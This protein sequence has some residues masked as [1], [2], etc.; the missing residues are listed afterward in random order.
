[1]TTLMKLRETALQL[2][3][4][5][6]ASNSRS[7]GLYTLIH[8]EDPDLGRPSV[9]KEDK[10]EHDTHDPQILGCNEASFCAA[11]ADGVPDWL[12]T[13]RTHR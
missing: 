7:K 3:S 2:L 1:M 6:T 4:I 11:G 5:S 9:R 8:T 12:S 13:A 10:F